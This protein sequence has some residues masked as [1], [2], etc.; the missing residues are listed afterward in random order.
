MI[1]GGCLWIG[2]LIYFGQFQQTF[3]NIINAEHRAIPIVHHVAINSE[4]NDLSF[5]VV[6]SSPASLVK[7]ASLDWYRVEGGLGL[8]SNTRRET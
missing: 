7:A 6:R 4:T 1:G 3:R 8:R 5:G 2:L